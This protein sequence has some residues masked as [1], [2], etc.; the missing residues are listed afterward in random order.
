MLELKS[1][2]SKIV[3][4]FEIIV[5]KKNENIVIAP[6]LVL[7]TVNGVNLSFKQRIIE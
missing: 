2:L 7:R 5:S 3:K 4:N 6:E 1:V